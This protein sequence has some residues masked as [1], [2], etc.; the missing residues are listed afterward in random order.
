M[1]KYFSE[2]NWAV[3][4][5]FKDALSLC[6]FEEGDTLFDTKLAYELKWGEAKKHIKNYIQIRYPTRANTSSKNS[7]FNGVF[8]KGWGSEVKLDL[9]KDHERTGVGQIYTT[10]GRLYTA[11]WTGD[12]NILDTSTP[13][14]K[15]PV[16]SKEINK[17][18]SNATQ[19]AKEL[20]NNGSPVF[21]MVY[22]QV[23]PVSIEKFNKISVS[24]NKY[25]LCLPILKK[26]N[27]VNILV[28]N[29]LPT[30]KIAF[31]VTKE[32]DNIILEELIKKVVYKPSPKAK[33]P[34]FSIKSHGIIV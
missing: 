4:S 7:K 25:L 6:K 2:F 29:I 20:S 22:D 19:K 5:A 24:L 34:K 15:I 31:F 13:E 18:L 3:P 17:Q 30:I 32:I 26:P 1:E 10:Q 14:P 9:Y 16:L 21:L 27:E 8:E 12:M 28:K 33:N 23:N 11:L